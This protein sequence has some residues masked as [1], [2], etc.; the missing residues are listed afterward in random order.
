MQT[1][2]ALARIDHPAV[3]A[4]TR[5]RSLLARVPLSVIEL[6]MRVGVALVFWKSG[7]TKI[8]S[9]DLT[10]ALFANE[11]QVPVLP[12][13]MAA[14]LGTAVELTAPVLLVLGIATRIGA[15]ALIGMTA[16]I[17]LFVFP[18]NWADHL[19]W[20]SILAYLVVRGPGALSI[21]HLIVR[22]WLGESTK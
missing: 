13:E 5:V 17:Q 15:A 7:M 3:R 19:L 21:D 9:W 11:Y 6:M 20:A 22:A 1:T 12:P 16:V 4:V 10:L 18:E 14:Y 2:V 8:A